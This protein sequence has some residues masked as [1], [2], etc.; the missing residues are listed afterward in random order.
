M[1][2]AIPA[3]DVLGIPG[4]TWLFQLLLHVTFLLHLVF[5]NLL[6]GGSLLVVVERL[7][8]RRTGADQEQAVGK[9][10]S[11]AR[12]VEEKLPTVFALTVTLGVAPLLFVQTLYGQFFYSSS[13]VMAWPWLSIILL[14]LVAYSLTYLLGWHGGRAGGWQR[15]VSVLLVVALLLIAFLLSN[16]MGLGLRPDAWAS[17]YFANPGGLHLNVD[18]PTFWPRLLHF[19]LAATAVTGM[20]LAVVGAW[21]FDR[22]DAEGQRWLRLGVVWFVIPTALQVVIGTW[23]LISLPRPILMPLL[24]SDG[25]TTTIF[26][27]AL[28]CAFVALI[29]MALAPLAKRAAPWVFGAAALLLVTLVGMILTRD[30]VRRNMLADHFHLDQ[31]NSVPQWNLIGLFLGLFVVS[32]AIVGWMI[33]VALKAGS[34]KDVNPAAR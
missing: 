30:A 20:V 25:W 15:P 8:A 23:W 14:L 3:P 2:P 19:L 18:D 27:T 13:V 11:L 4:P 28:T 1:N 29:I 10:V 21:R 9:T 34:G 31:W 17:K 6:V 26:L 24:G 32:L 16:N 5:M 12:W 22:G 33:V 7:R